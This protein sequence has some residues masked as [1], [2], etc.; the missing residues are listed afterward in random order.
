MTLK[1]VATELKAMYDQA[2]VGEMV[3]MILL[4]G[5]RYADVIKANGYSVQEII[6]QAG[7]RDSY[8]T[9]VSKGVKLAKYVGFT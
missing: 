3:T 4:F 6:A 1:E 7:M 5:I 9:E 2:E 8:A